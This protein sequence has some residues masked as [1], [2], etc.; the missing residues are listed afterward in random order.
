MS[1]IQM[2]F[3][4]KAI[5]LIGA[6]G[7]SILENLLRSKERKILPVNSHMSKVLDVE[8]H[9]TVGDAPEH[10][11]LA[12]LATPARGQCRRQEISPSSLRAVRWAVRLPL[13]NCAA[14]T[15]HGSVSFFVRHC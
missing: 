13:R 9:P 12:V 8:S 5:A 4:P 11:D 3:D 2:M 1:R 7:R 6:I 14:G 10:V 15:P